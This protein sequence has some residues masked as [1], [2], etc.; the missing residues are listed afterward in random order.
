MNG[1][2]LLTWGEFDRTSDQFGRVWFRYPGEP[3]SSGH[4]E[5]QGVDDYRRKGPPESIVLT[6]TFKD[7]NALDFTAFHHM[8][9]NHYRLF[10]DRQNHINEIENFWNQVKR[11]LRRFNGIKPEQFPLVSQGVRMAPQWRQPSKPLQTS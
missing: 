11:H 8:Q 5:T 10:S 4:D 3:R 2:R 1:D 6:D 7:Y 9:I